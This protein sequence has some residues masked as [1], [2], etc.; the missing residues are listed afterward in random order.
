MPIDADELAD[1]LPPTDPAP[2]SELR[3]GE[4][5]DGVRLSGAALTGDATGARFLECV[6]ADCDLGGVGFDRARLASCLLTGVRSPA[7]SLLDARLLDVVVEGGRFGAVTAH[8]SDLTRVRLGSL[9]VDY[10]GLRNAT[11]VDVTLA[12]CTIGELDLA[13]AD[14]R[15]LRLAGCTVGSLV[16]DG[17]RCRSVDLRSARVDRLDGVAGLRGCTIDAAQLV[18]WA[19]DL[20]AEL[21]ITV[22]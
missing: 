22:G 14:L 10:L 21:G 4:A 8:G 16:L 9:K 5:T 20:A 15:D 12:G 7:W 17:A 11:L 13:G 1:L 2:G 18:A 6:V 3:G 19:P